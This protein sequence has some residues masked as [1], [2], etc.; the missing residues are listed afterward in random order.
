MA[1]KKCNHLQLF[2]YIAFCVI[3]LDKMIILEMPWFY[4]VSVTD[5]V[6][7]STSFCYSI[8]D[9][10]HVLLCCPL[11]SSET[12]LSIWPFPLNITISC[13]IFWFASISLHWWGFKNLRSLTSNSFFFGEHWTAWHFWKLWV[14]LV[15]YNFYLLQEVEKV[16]IL[17]GLNIFIFPRFY[18]I[19]WHCTN[20]YPASFYTWIWKQTTFFAGNIWCFSTYYH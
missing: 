12:Y 19:K 20:L 5:F 6:D 14:Q 3:F 1:K 4:F 2:Q 11:R 13:T 16:G 17:A 15:Y 8:S 10:S 7:F 9:K 18:E